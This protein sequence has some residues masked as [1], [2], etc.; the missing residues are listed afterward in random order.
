M[1]HRAFFSKGGARALLLGAALVALPLQ[2][3]DVYKAYLD[4]AIP[5]HRAILDT[6]SR[7]K[8]KPND[9][10]LHNDL[11]CLVAWDGFWRDALSE[12]DIAAKLDKTDSRPL[13][14][15]GLVEVW[16]GRWGAAK[17]RFAAA[18][19]RGPG[20][21]PAWWMLG[22]AEENLGNTSAAV[23]AYRTSLRVDTSLFEVARNPFAADTTLKSRVLLEDYDRRVARASMPLREEFADG[24]R[25]SK[26]FQRTGAVPPGGTVSVTTKEEPVPTGPTGPIVTTAPPAS[27]GPP[28]GR[29]V[30]PAPSPVRV[31]PRRLPQ[32][33]PNADQAAP[34]DNL[35]FNQVTPAPKP[36]RTPRPL[37]PGGAPP[38][39]EE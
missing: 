19:K 37:G 28:Q 4:P 25:V 23:K 5:H 12:F 8:E 39:D 17:G 35:P 26:F 11:G 34:P 13:F 24:D 32:N 21:W 16:R 10:G 29:A 27:S 33:D 36:K 18:T 15:A 38:D 2:A 30:Q 9:A 6:L 20:N 31:P 7:L 3:K 22:F 14:N 1:I